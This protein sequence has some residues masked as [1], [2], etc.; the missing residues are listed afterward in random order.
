MY[1]I[2]PLLQC[3]MFH[4]DATTLG[5]MHI[6]VSALLAMSGRITM[7]GISR[8]SGKGGSYRTI[9]RFFNTVI[10]WPTVMWEFFRYHCWCQDDTYLLIGDEV[11]VTKSGKKNVWSGPLL[12]EFV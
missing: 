6:V 7:Q 4:L 2:L 9:Q 10:P 8:W 3:L 5:R 12:F 1:E 11:V